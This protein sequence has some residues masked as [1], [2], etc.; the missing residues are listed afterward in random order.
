MFNCNAMNMYTL[1]VYTILCVD[2]SPVATNIVHGSAEC[3]HLEKKRKM[4]LFQF[5]FNLYVQVVY[6]EW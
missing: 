6:I 5:I 1:T 2:V 3:K 4:S